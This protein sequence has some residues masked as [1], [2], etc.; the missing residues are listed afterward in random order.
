MQTLLESEGRLAEV[1]A[2]PGLLGLDMLL[3]RSQLRTGYP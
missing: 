1:K 3:G 2:D